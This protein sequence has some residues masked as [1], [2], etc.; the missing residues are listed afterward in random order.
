[1]PVTS[2]IDYE[3]PHIF[4]VCESGCLIQSFLLRHNCLISLIM[5]IR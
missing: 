4:M 5:P 2:Q 3:H 1:M